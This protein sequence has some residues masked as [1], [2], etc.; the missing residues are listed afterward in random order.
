MV[1][2]LDEAWERARR[3]VAELSRED[4]P[5]S[6]NEEAEPSET[7]WCWIFSFSSARYFET[8]SPMD[9]L[10]SGPIVVNKDGSEEWVAGSAEPD[11]DIADYGRAHGYA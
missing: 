2:E 11:K 6:L 1:V 10:L 7:S 5:M 8:R 3:K 4:L 9:L